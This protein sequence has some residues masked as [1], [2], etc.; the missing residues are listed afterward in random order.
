MLFEEFFMS[1]N[2]ECNTQA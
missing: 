1:S 2:L